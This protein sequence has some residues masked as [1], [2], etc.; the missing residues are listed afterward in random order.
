VGLLVVGVVLGGWQNTRRSKN[1]V[2]PVTSTLQSVTQPV[3]SMF[4]WLVLGTTDFVRGVASSRALMEENRRL[5]DSLVAARLYTEQMDR[6]EN[7][8]DHLRRLQGIG[9]RP[10]V[11]SIAA[12]ITGF[13]PYENR[14]TIDIG[15]KNGIHAGMPVVCADGLVGIVQTVE[16]SR[17]QA[18]MLTSKSVQIGAMALGHNPPPAGLIEGVNSSSLT[19]NLL[20]PKAPIT[21]GDTIVTSGFGERIPRGLVIGKVIQ[22]EDDAQYGKRTAQIDPAVSIGSIQEVKVLR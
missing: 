17:S 16:A 13:Y 3:A 11:D 22:I 1:E 15:A 9:N 4:E 10:G 12:R 19:L 18:L 20:D 7:D 21:I 2:D 8:L 6:L 5:R 14:I